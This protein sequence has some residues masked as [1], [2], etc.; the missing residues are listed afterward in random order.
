MDKDYHTAGHCPGGL[1]EF[2]LR[3]MPYYKFDVNLQDEVDH[4]MLP[5]L[6]V[7]QVPLAL[8]HDARVED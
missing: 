1:T 8:T 2:L 5:E 4:D 7:E 6:E 3:R